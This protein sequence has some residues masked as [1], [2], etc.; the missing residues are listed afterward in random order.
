MNTEGYYYFTPE[1]IQDI[2]GYNKYA[3]ELVDYFIVWGP[4]T[5]KMLGAYLLKDK[6]V[7]DIRR[8]KVTG[9]AWY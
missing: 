7:S 3:E 2:I 9:Y 6:K 5:K 4:K 8:V 1:S